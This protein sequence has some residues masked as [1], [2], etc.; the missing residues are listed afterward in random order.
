MAKSTSA[1]I[2]ALDPQ[3]SR[4]T[5][6]KHGFCNVGVS[7][8]TYGLGGKVWYKSLEGSNNVNMRPMLQ[9]AMRRS[10]KLFNHFRRPPNKEEMGEKRKV[11]VTTSI[12]IATCRCWI[13]FLPI[14][15]SILILVLNIRGVYIGQDFQGPLKS[16]TINLMFLQLAAKA[17]ELC[18]VA[19][20]AFIVQHSV[21]NELLFG[22]GLPLGL[23][24]S[25][26]SFSSLGFFFTKEFYGA[27]GYITTHSKK[28]RKVAFISLLIIAGLIATLAG[29]ASAVLLVPQTRQWPSGGT[30]IF[31][32]ASEESFWP[33]DL[34]GAMPV[35]E[36]LCGNDT[37]TDVAV[38]PA[39]GFRSLSEHWRRLNY[40]NFEQQS[41]PSYA[42]NMSGSDFY[43][44]VHSPDSLLAPLYSMGNIRHGMSSTF[45]VQPH[46]AA[47]TILQQTTLDWWTALTSPGRTK[48]SLI[49]DRQVVTHARSAI[50]STRCAQP[51]VLLADDKTIPMP[52]VN[53]RFNFG[54]ALDFTDN[55]ISVAPT[56]HIRFNWVHQPIEYGAASIGAVFQ[57]P[58]SDT[59]T[60]RVAIGCTVQTGWVPT[61][62]QTDSYTFWTGWYPWN[63]SFGER[64]P[65]WSRTSNA[66][67]NGRIALGD[68]WLD[69]LTPTISSDTDSSVEDW[70]PST[71]E[72]ILDSVGITSPDSS[73]GT[74]SLL[75]DWNASD[76]NDRGRTAYIECLISSILVDGLS[77]TGSA[78][79]FDTSNGPS[80]QWPFAWYRPLPN[81]AHLI[82]NGGGTHTVANAAFRP[83]AGPPDSFVTLKSTMAISG[84][85]LQL[86]LSGI[87]AMVVLL[88]HILMAT[89]DMVWILINRHTSHSWS[90]VSE[91]IALAQNSQPAFDVLA[92][93]SSGIKCSSTF[94]RLAK[95]RVVRRQR[96]KPAAAVVSSSQSLS[97]SATASEHVELVFQHVGMPS[98]S[99]SGSTLTFH[100]HQHSGLAAVIDT[101]TDT[102]RLLAL[103]RV[104]LAVRHDDDRVVV[105]QAYG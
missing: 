38:C 43:W 102:D 87:L 46:A 30:Q 69:M 39:G 68:T 11:I 63:V 100:Q 72:S 92:N 31:L 58:W 65:A 34:T 84:F 26:L 53:G 22:D 88:T 105:N 8:Q 17:Q 2:S 16:Q 79:I 15:T 47:A 40:T 19:S 82:L 73:K 94:S 55:N 96:E 44:P 75:E 71:I 50:V 77:R 78:L 70:Q 99:R 36:Q 74:T 98:R 76:G 62:V 51:L 89:A 20:L 97:L 25:G 21:R 91:L 93:T 41:V 33:A 3:H 5:A 56:H 27:I 59:N 10:V 42:K 28:S 67:T 90:T 54:R 61:N 80:S 81:F 83:P 9:K 18:I 13:H 49:D 7:H 48:A 24:G 45:L 64:T 85:S 52:A 60:S 103:P 101:D 32:P 95:I 1:A 23:I 104:H 37:S 86:S 4:G 12:R 35:L 66:P 57:S 29:P 14:A 6:T